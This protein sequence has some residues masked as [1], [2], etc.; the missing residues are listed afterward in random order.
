MTGKSKVTFIE[1]PPIT[2]RV[3]ERLAGCTYEIHHFP[4]LA[5]LGLLSLLK[6]EGY[7]VNLIDAVLEEI[8]REDFFKIIAEDDSDYYVIHSCILAKP[9]DL[10]TIARIYE[11]R[12]KSRVFF[13]GPEPTRVPW[14]Y[15]DDERTV[16][17]RGEPEDNMLEFLEKGT[18]PG[19][20]FKKKYEIESLPPT[21]R[22]VNLDKLPVPDRLFG[23]L[24]KYKDRFFNPKFKGRPYTAMM[25]SRGCAHRCLFCVPNSLSFAR[26]LECIKY[27]G[28]KPKVAKVS[29]ARVIE[30]FR[31]VAAQGFK[32]MMV[33]DDQFLWD[34]PRSLEICAGVAPLKLEW[35]I[36]SRADYLLDEEVI[37]ALKDSGCTTIDIGVESLCQKTLDFVR[38]DITV[39]QVDRSLS[40]LKKYGID[41]K[42]NMIIGACPAETEA[43]IQ[44]GLE[45][46]KEM[47]V[48]NVMFSIATPFKGTEF[49]KLCE[50]EGYLID[51][52]DSLDPLNKAMISYPNLPA[53]KL[54]KLEKK[55]YRDFYLRPE[56]IWKRIKNI[57]NLKDLVRD[58]GIALKIF[59]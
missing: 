15:L 38:K 30:E 54:E 22:Q 3:P 52:S 40:L 48:E 20:S 31:A 32:S 53:E 49:Y 58:I 13:H 8:P 33:I 26:E 18:A 16:V 2:D 7:E 29:A 47:D 9:T 4:D 41:A 24:G 21:G 28:K 23:P 25:A 55:A 57:K 56:K 12:P 19:T 44:D 1:P 17:F 39:D 45:K 37:K 51:E 59:T 34:K 35:G 6:R 5:Q 14:E 27:F 36:L 43:D 46:L 10:M 42:L 50:D 11:V